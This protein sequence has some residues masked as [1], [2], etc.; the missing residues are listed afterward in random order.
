MRWDARIALEAPGVLHSFEMR[1]DFPPMDVA[2]EE[3]RFVEPVALSG[4]AIADDNDEIHV[5]LRVNAKLHAA[6]ARCLEEYDFSITASVNETFLKEYDP[7]E[8]EAP[9]YAQDTLDFDEIAEQA[10]RLELPMVMVCR[11]DCRGLC[12][13]CGKDRNRGDCDCHDEEVQ[14]SNGGSQE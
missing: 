3:V 13:R 8:P 2:G 4:K 12:P 11:P 5:M 1:Q 6:C 7:E 10:I 9:L 14:R